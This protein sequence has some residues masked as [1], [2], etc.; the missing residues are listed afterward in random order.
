MLREYRLHGVGRAAF[1]RSLQYQPSP[2]LPAYH[3][4]CTALASLGRM[5]P[6]G[7]AIERDNASRAYVSAV[8]GVRHPTAAISIH[9]FPP[10]FSCPLYCTSFSRSPGTIRR[11]YR[12]VWNRSSTSG[13]VRMNAI[14]MKAIQTD[15]DS[16]SIRA[17]SRGWLIQ[18]GGKS[19]GRGTSALLEIRHDKRNR[20]SIP[21]G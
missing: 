11:G 10:C 13:E 14:E 5:G 12:G 6:I 8:R 3:V 1:P 15:H 17:C 4:H 18:R 7:E 2:F 19:V 20:E 9:P 16:V 21:K